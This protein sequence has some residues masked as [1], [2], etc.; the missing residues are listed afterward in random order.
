MSEI[1]HNSKY[2]PGIATYGI[3]ILQGERGNSGY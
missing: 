2:T 3:K 1:L